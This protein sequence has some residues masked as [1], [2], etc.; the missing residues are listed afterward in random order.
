MTDNGDSA[1]LVFTDKGWKS[2]L[3]GL[4]LLGFG[5]LCFRVA[6]LRPGE[7]NGWVPWVVGA[8]FA[9]VG[10]FTVFG[11]T[12]TVFDGATRTWTDSW[13]FLFL[14]FSKSGSFDQLDRVSVE[15]S[16]TDGFTRYYIWVKGGRNIRLLPETTHS[17]E[18]ADRIAAALRALIAP[19]DEGAGDA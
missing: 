16:V 4:L 12:R 19:R 6:R 1:R 11:R 5:L 13:G 14:N 18:E 3:G 15:E 9:S 10:L 8:F 17:K 7:E 2:A